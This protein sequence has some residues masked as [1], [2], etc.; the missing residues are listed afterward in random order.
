MGLTDPTY[1]LLG[2]F[3]AAIFVTDEFRR[4]RR[5]HR[6]WRSELRNEQ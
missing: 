1:L 2:L 3:I 6:R 4:T 5:E